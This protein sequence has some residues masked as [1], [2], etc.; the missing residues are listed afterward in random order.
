MMKS[1]VLTLILIFP[2][3]AFGQNRREESLKY[4]GQ[5]RPS[6]TPERFAP[7]LVSVTNQSEFGSIFTGDGKEFYYAVDIADKAEIRFMRL[8]KGK[9]TKPITLISDEVFSYNDPMLSP[10]ESKLY[11]ISDQPFDNSEKKKDYDIWY[12]ERTGDG[13]STPVNAGS[14]IN[15]GKDEYYV[16]LSKNGTIYFSSN[17]KTEGVAK[18]NF[19]IFSSI[20]TLGVYKRAIPLNDS[21]NTKD[22]EADVFVAR[23]ESYLI[24]CG[25]RIDGYGRGDLYISYRKPD[26]T[27]TKAKNMGKTI[28]TA[29][30]EL[31]PFVT[32]DGKYFLYT[33][34]QDIYWVDTRIINDLRQ[35][36]N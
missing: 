4:L 22:Y 12:V 19:N 6:M 10:D 14:A 33:S 23:D 34:N 21:I 26:G 3:I 11:F 24:F 17:R 32:K 2:S 30:H 9:W 5:R 18:G 35:Q 29:G 16:T 27:W 13:W 7:E 31:C 1:I 8:H 28:N 20:V 36:K 25:D 15:S